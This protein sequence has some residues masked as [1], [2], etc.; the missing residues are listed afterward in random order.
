MN[1][2]FDFYTENIRGK[3][4]PFI[5]DKCGEFGCKP[6]KDIYIALQRNQKKLFCSKA[7][8]HI[9]SETLCKCETCN[10]KFYKKNREIERSAN[11]FCSHTCS[12]QYNNE[13]RI[14]NGF[15]TKGLTKICQC[16]I[17]KIPYEIF[18]NSTNNFICEK[19]SPIKIKEYIPR[20]PYNRTV[21][22]EYHRKIKKCSY[23]NND[24]TTPKRKTCSDVCNK[25]A[26]TNGARKGGK[27]SAYIQSKNKRSKNEILF[28]ELCIPLDT[29]ILTNV[30]M[31]NGWDADIILPTFKV[32]IL[33]NG[34]WH[35]KKI[36]E[37]H[38]V[39]QV[40]NRDSIKI[41][42]IEKL[43]YTTYIIKDM[44][45]YNPTFVLEQFDIFNMW[46]KRKILNFTS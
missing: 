26:K 31:F 28:A 32:A 11:N 30:P 25:M 5:C 24:F 33:W 40:Q 45:K 27:I 12:A 37:K 36:T 1:F 19:C 15:T 44:G 42:E 10:K 43:N 4:I 17:C 13:K 38:S 29:K 35:Y 39:S 46:L 7:C 3:S 34:A 21:P 41:K 9:K 20:K 2:D 6:R 23:C 22:R 8:S 18:L 16:K 14:R